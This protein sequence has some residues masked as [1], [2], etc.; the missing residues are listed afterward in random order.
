MKKHKNS[1]YE[2][3]Y[4]FIHNIFLKVVTISH[5]LL[6]NFR[7]YDTEKITKKS[8]IQKKL[9]IYKQVYNKF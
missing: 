5:K 2:L 1:L 6:T 7:F 4:N 3:F 8:N 9:N